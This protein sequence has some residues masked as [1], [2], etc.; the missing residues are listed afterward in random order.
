MSLW[1]CL[2]RG[3]AAAKVRAIHGD[4]G[5][6]VGLREAGAEMKREKEKEKRGCRGAAGKMALA[7][8]AVRSVPY[9]GADYVQQKSTV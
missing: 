3:A 5:E 1:W 4:Y 9:H 6:D 2:G 8:P 7:L